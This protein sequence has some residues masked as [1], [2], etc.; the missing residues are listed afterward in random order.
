M[1]KNARTVLSG[2]QKKGF[3]SRDN[4]HRFLHLWVDNHKTSIYTKISHGERDIGDNLLGLMARQI[5]LTRRQFLDLVDCPL[6]EEEYVG[7]LRNGGHID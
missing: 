7:I 3:Q 6:S 1:P 4:D 5:R 2:L